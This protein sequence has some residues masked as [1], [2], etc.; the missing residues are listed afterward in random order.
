MVIK[1]CQVQKLVKRSNLLATVAVNEIIMKIKQ[2]PSTVC[3]LAADKQMLQQLFIRIKLPD[4]YNCI[5]PGLFSDHNKQ[6]RLSMAQVIKA[7]GKTLNLF[8]PN[9]S[10]IKTVFVCEALI[11][12]LL[13]KVAG[14]DSFLLSLLVF[15]DAS[16]E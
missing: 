11:V 6:S 9:G 16:V 1:N 3:F 13:N 14:F 15:G 10:W 5:Y 2:D 8:Y 12:K 7:L 4:H